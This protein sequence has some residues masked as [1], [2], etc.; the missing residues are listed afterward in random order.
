ML[1]IPNTETEKILGKLENLP[2]FTFEGL[3]TM[4]GK[5]HDQCKVMVN[6]WR[7]R[8]Y[9]MRIKRGIYTTR[10][11]YKRHMGDLYYMSSIASIIDPLSY[12]SLEYILQKNNIL[13]EAVYSVTSVTPKTTR[14]TKNDFG[15]FYY[16]SI[17]RELFGG[18]TTTDYKGINV[19]EATA[20]KALFDYMYFRTLP[21]MAKKPDFNVAEDL[22]LNLDDFSKDQVKDF[23][24]WCDISN[25]RKMMFIKQNFEEYVWKN[26]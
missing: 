10:E 20:E 18:F 26:H 11:Y 14:K 23:N 1:T 8:G 5:P 15:R 17:K 7:K 4:A 21:N 25:V 16:R 6:R 22:R 9:L 3:A 24:K 13:T 19:N 12:V 2:Y